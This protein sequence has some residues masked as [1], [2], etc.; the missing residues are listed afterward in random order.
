MGD[1]P[2]LVFFPCLG[3]ETCACDSYWG[4]ARS[5]LS[6]AFNIGGGGGGGVGVDVLLV[7]GF[8]VG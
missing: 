3:V 6:T 7:P 5:I 8:T 1:F 2:I 4:E